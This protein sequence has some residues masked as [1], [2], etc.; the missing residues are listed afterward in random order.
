[1]FSLRLCTNKECK[2]L[3]V[4][5]VCYVCGSST[6]KQLPEEAFLHLQEQMIELAEVTVEIANVEAKLADLENSVQG[7]QRLANPEFYK[8]GA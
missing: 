3:N 7:L 2:M 4:I 1:M 6:V 8:E 5:S